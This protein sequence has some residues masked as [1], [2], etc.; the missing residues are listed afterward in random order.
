MEKT[1]LIIKGTKKYLF[2]NDITQKNQIPFDW[3]SPKETT[4]HFSETPL[5]HYR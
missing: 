2:L 1:V 3:I 5:A 4:H